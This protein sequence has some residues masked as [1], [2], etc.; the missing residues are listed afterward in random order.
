MQE[1]GRN[2]GGDAGIFRFHVIPINDTHKHIM[3]RNCECQPH[4]VIDEENAFICISHHSWDGREA[5]EELSVCCSG[6]TFD[7]E[8]WITIEY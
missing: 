6:I 5:L 2:N 8:G 1:E 3:S 7:Y 4:V